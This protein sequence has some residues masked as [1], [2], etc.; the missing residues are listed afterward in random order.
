MD[1]VDCDYAALHLCLD[2]IEEE[3]KNKMSWCILNDKSSTSNYISPGKGRKVH[4]EMTHEEVIF[5]AHVC[6][7]Y[8]FHTFCH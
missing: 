2:S 3:C 7:Y 4:M 6:K 1:V 8:S 5:C